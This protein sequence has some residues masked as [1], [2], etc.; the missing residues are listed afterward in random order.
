MT[1]FVAW[2]TFHVVFLVVATIYVT[3]VGYRWKGWR[4]AVRA[5]PSSG[6]RSA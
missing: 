1:V 5:L 6:S 3:A 4:S 2:P